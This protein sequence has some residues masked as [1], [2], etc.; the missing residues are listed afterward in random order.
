MQGLRM[1]FISDPI[2]HRKLLVVSSYWYNFD[3]NYWGA[4]YK[5][6]ENKHL[7]WKA[8]YESDNRLGYASLWVRHSSTF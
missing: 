8:G 3:T 1:L 5:H 4:T 2:E 6:K 7:K